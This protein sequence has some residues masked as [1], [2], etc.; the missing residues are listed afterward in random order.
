MRR[1]QL[2]LGIACLFLMYLTPVLG[3]VSNCDINEF[4]P[5]IIYRMQTIDNIIRLSK[6]S[7]QN[8]GLYFIRQDSLAA[9]ILHDNGFHASLTE[10]YQTP[11]DELRGIISDLEFNDYKIIIR[12][13]RSSRLREI[14]YCKDK[15]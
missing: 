1:I 7:L 6:Q 3:Q 5:H 14:V 2:S 11:V 9:N 12:S 15:I 8:L 4:P 13:N 10:F